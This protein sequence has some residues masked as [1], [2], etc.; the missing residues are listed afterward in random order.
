VSVNLGDSEA[1][2]SVHLGS[3]G[4]DLQYS[5]ILFQRADVRTVIEQFLDEVDA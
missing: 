4:S 5:K 1:N 3:L 2:G